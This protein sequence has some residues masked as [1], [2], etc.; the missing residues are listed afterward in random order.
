MSGLSSVLAT[1]DAGCAVKTAQL[2]NAVWK[3][4][5]S[6]FL[7]HVLLETSISGCCVSGGIWTALCT[8]KV[9]FGRGGLLGFLIVAGG[10]A[11]RA[12]GAAGESEMRRF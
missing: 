6:L 11:D 10:G 2:P 7:P 12:A 4:L 5:S 1:E 3:Q 9:C 8:A